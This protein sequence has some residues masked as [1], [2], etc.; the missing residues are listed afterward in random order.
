M[1]VYIRHP[2]D[3]TIQYYTSDSNEDFDDGDERILKDISE[4]SICFKSE[5]PIQKNSKI[6]IKIP[7]SQP[8][9]EADGFVTWCKKNQN[10]DYEI[11]VKFADDSIE[12]TLRMVE[13]A[14][15]IKHYMLTEKE[16]GREINSDEAA[17]EWISKYA[18]EFPR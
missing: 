11:G 14:C 18:S 15:H 1:R 5:T 3:V 2:F 4:G 13:Q 7:I 17:E 8:A 16:L 9:F 12:F 10:S 6:H